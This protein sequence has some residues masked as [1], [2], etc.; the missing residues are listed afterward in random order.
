MAQGKKGGPSQEDAAAGVE[1]R[2]ETDPNIVIPQAPEVR[3]TYSRRFFEDHGLF[4]WIQ[5]FRLGTAGYRDTM[6]MDNFFA[7]DAPYNAHTIMIIG[8]AVARVYNR[9]GLSSIH[10]GGEVRRY[11]SQIIEL[12]GRIFARHG[13]MGTR[14]F[15]WNWLCRKLGIGGRSR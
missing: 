3:I 10:L 9:K 14:E 8:E 11:T 15:N 13:I 2:V 12:L 6:D 7:T 5:E 1:I 4:R